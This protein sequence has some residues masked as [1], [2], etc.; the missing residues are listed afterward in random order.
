[1]IRGIL[2]AASCGFVFQNYWLHKTNFSFGSPQGKV[3]SWRFC[4]R[5][6]TKSCQSPLATVRQ[7]SHG[8]MQKISNIMKDNDQTKTNTQVRIE[9]CE[10]IVDG[11]RPALFEFFRGIEA[12]HLLEELILPAMAGG[13]SM[14][15]VAYTERPW[16]PWGIGG[17]RVEGAML[18]HPVG[19]RNASLMPP[20]TTYENAA[21]IG[22]QTILLKK[23]LE[24]LIKRGKNDVDFLLADTSKTCARVIAAAGFEKTK[25]PVLTQQGK[26][27]FH[28]AKA[29]NVLVK[30]GLVKLTSIQLLA[31]IEDQTIFNRNALFQLAIRAGFEASWHGVN[32]WSEAIANTGGAV[33]TSPPGGGGGGPPPTRGPNFGFVHLEELR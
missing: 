27:L 10:K 15:F 18:V 20:F 26:Y 32:R 24:E 21:N 23:T 33:S 16:P 31:G 6:I 28:R 19:E 22:L 14:L 7:L 25:D 9:S 8:G 29:K 30:L 12:E 17:K 11:F 5:S 1:M 4:H 3:P 13:N 2:K